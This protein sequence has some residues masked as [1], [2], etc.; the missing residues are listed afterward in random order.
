MQ[1]SVEAP[2]EEN[3]E[4]VVQEGVINIG[5]VETA[6]KD[7]DVPAV[8]TVSEEGTV[9]RDTPDQTNAASVAM[10]ASQFRSK[11]TQIQNGQGKGFWHFFRSLLAFFYR[12]R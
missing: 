8:E 10:V 5:T 11:K 3:A 9:S 1:D 7:A 12:K 2:D 4:S 6:S